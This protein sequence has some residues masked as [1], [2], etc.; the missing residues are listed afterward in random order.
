[1]KQDQLK[2]LLVTA[3][4]VLEFAITVILL[5]INNKEGKLKNK[6]TSVI[7]YTN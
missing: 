6:F 3:L 2:K 5:Y 7:G 1:M 4:L